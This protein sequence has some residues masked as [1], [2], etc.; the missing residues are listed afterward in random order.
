MILLFL[1][2]ISC[3]WTIRRSILILLRVSSLVASFVWISFVLH[4]R[5]EWNAI[6]SSS[7]T[8]DFSLL[9]TLMEWNESFWCEKFV[10][11][12]Q[13]RFFF[14][15]Y[16]CNWKADCSWNLSAWQTWNLLYCLWFT[17]GSWKVISPH[18]F[19]LLRTG[20]LVP[21]YCGVDLYWAVKSKVRMK[22]QDHITYNH[23]QL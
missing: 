7:P 1:I 13:Y 16:L 5:S 23:Q 12:L 3:C 4:S 17:R 15:N 20:N 21:F 6:F 22:H 19:R 8:T 9:L 10:A 11:G 14:P 2:W 18:T